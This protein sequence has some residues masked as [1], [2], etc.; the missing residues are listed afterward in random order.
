VEGSRKK[1]A[2]KGEEMGGGVRFYHA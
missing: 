1:M 2:Y